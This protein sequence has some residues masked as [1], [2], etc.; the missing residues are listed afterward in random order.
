MSLTKVTYAM[1]QGDPI[2][3]Q[4]FGA[5]GDGVTDDIA[6]ITAA[7]AQAV[8]LEKGL[9]FE[10]GKTYLVSTPINI[11][12]SLDTVPKWIDFNA[13]TIKASATFSGA[14]IIYVEN[15][16]G[17]VNTFWM[18]NVFIDGN[19]KVVNYGLYVKGSQ[20][21]RFSSIQVID[22]ASHGFF[23]QGESGFGIYYNI[24]DTCKSGGPGGK[25]N[26]GDGWFISGVGG[27]FANS[28]TFLNCAS[29]YNASGG[30]RIGISS[31]NSFI[32][33]A[34]EESV[35][36]AGF[37]FGATVT[38]VSIIGGFTENNDYSG[39]DTSFR[40]LSGANVDNIKIWGGRH[41]GTI[42]GDFTQDGIL[43]AIDDVASE[44]VWNTDLSIR[45]LT[46]GGF[47]E[48][49]I[50][51]SGSTVQFGKS[52][53]PETTDTYNLGSNLL[54]WDRT[55]T[56]TLALTDGVSTP[57]TVSGKAFLYVD[58]ADGDLKVRFGD[59]TIKTIVTDT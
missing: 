17:K 3:V 12:S 42:N 6:A 34:A 32:G 24:F 39:T 4:D 44:T 18:S 35:A 10:S 46:L 56:N 58:S 28:N 50:S 53:V 31:G 30:F 5:V 1:I 51:A 48:N 15:P 52:A 16:Q 20:D 22:C 36:D 41:N 27:R 49:T 9:V 2:N 29:Q 54:I 23:I 40:I 33:C 47:G 38:S 8:L 25:G 21:A 43:Y 37:V 59:G 57:S 19:G 45:N 14:Q 26:D 11:S 7:I 55:H 13:C